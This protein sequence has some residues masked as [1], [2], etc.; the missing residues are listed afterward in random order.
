MFPFQGCMTIAIDKPESAGFRI[1]TA[2]NL[3]K[4]KINGAFDHHFGRVFSGLRSQSEASKWFGHLPKDCSCLG[5]GPLFTCNKDG[6]QARLRLDVDVHG[7][8]QCWGVY[9]WFLLIWR[10]FFCNGPTNQE[11]SLRQHRHS[12]QGFRYQKDHILDPTPTMNSML[13]NPQTRIHLQSQ[14]NP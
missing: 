11:Q 13:L 10:I 4:K 6:V 7:Y 14:V 3:A 5:C 8:I 2:E 12:R 9:I 1:K